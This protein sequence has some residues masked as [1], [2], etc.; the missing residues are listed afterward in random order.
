MVA[1]VLLAG[2]GRG[3]FWTFGDS[4][5]DDEGDAADVDCDRADFVFVID[6]SPSMQAYQRELVDNFP[7]FVDGVQRVVE[8]GT[9]LHVGV[10][11]TD[12]YAGN[13]A[14]C[15]VMGG[16]VVATT[17]AHSSRAQ[18]GPYAEGKSYMTAADDLASSFACAAQVGTMGDQTERPADALRAAIDPDGDAAACNQGFLRSDAL[19]IAVLVTDEPDQSHGGPTQ[20]SREVLAAKGGNQDGVVVVSLLDGGAPGCEDDPEN[21]CWPWELQTFTESFDYGF[22]G[23]ITGDYGEIF[24]Q[25]VDVVASACAG[26]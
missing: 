13:P 19:L 6:D 25:A 20:W 15:D 10:V 26:D 11:T 2:C 1:W 24:D 3:P 12:A 17:G 16:F 5:G 9:D 18:C 23:Q 7:A 14:P 4:A 21:D 22:L 8:H